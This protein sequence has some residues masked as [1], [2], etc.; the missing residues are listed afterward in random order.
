VLEHCPKCSEPFLL[1]KTTK[2]Q[3]TFRYCGNAEC[4]YRSNESEVSEA[5]KAKAK[6]KAK[7]T[8]PVG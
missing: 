1:E 8:A 3:G 2:K 4:G 7:K 6:P 5:P